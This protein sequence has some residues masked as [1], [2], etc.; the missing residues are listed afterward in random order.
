[1]PVTRL[2][3]YQAGQE[4]FYISL[5]PDQF[6]LAHTNVYVHYDSDCTAVQQF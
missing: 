2:F 4:A 5:R 6:K 3:T 1:M